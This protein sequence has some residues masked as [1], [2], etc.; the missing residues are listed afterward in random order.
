MEPGDGV[1]T[2]VP[3]TKE[4]LDLA[5]EALGQLD[6]FGLQDRFEELCDE[7]EDRFGLRTGEPLRSNTTDATPVASELADRIAEDNALDME[8]YD[9]ACRLYEG[10][11]P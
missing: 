1:L 6:V 9:Y 2:T 5:K 4:R 11:H 10:R 8:L 7:L 3:Y